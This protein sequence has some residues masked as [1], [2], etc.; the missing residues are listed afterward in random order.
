MLRHLNF[1]LGKLEQNQVNVREFDGVQRDTLG[2]VTLTL[3]MGPVEFS[4]QFQ[5]F[6][7]VTSYNLLLERPF[8][9]M[10][11]VIPSTLY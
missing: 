5:L 11:G 2:A 4:A 1:D 7:I 9:H 3:Q 6:H 10:A 8:I